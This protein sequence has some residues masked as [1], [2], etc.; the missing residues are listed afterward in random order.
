[1]PEVAGNTKERSQSRRERARS[2]GKHKRTVTFKVG[3]CPK[4]PKK[5]KKGHI[6]GRNVPEVAGKT[7]EGSHSRWERARIAGNTKERSQSR[8]ERARSRGKNKRTVTFK[9]GTCPKSPK[10]QKNGHIQVRNVP[11][12][13]ESTKERSHS[14]EERARSRR[15]HKRTV[16]FRGGTCPKS[17]KTQK[18]GHIQV[19]NVPEVTENTKERAHSR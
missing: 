6:Q 2:R 11:E 15:K 19:R 16:T 9:V 18:N 8:K 17:P 12:V 7:K 1:V 14:G 10:T 5:Q 4:S 3:T 13:A